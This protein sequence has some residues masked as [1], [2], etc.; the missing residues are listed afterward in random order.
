MSSTLGQ[1]VASQL[2]EKNFQC[3]KFRPGVWLGP[4]KTKTN[5][6]AWRE[7]SV[8]NVV[9]GELIYDLRYQTTGVWFDPTKPD[10]PKYVAPPKKKNNEKAPM[11]SPLPTQLSR[12]YEFTGGI[13]PGSAIS[14]GFK[15]P[16]PS[17]NMYGAASG[18]I[19]TS[20]LIN[21]VSKCTID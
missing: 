11:A 15:P 9:P 12:T 14:S 6:H 4:E 1:D 16:T 10:K 21:T 18:I 17:L 7:I 20:F 13:T 8:G 2:F 3:D 5:K 19:H